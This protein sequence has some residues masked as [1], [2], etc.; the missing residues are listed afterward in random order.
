MRGFWSDKEVEE[1]LREIAEDEER[2]EKDDGCPLW[3]AMTIAMELHRFIERLVAQ[4]R[5]AAEPVSLWA[6]AEYMQ[7][8][9]E[10]G[11][12]AQF[13]VWNFDIYQGPPILKELHRQPSAGLLNERLADGLCGTVV[14]QLASRILANEHARHTADDG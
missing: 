13:D 2:S 10:E 6:V 11:R 9:L 7:L 5:S 14:V 3:R 1:I 4:V 8:A 12:L